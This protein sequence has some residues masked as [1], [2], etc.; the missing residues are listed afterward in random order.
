P[1]ET[2][3]LPIVPH[4]GGHEQRD[5]LL[6]HDRLLR[7]SRGAKSG[8]GALGGQ[9][10]ERGGRPAR[11]KQRLGENQLILAPRQ[12]RMLERARRI[13]T[14]GGIDLRDLRRRRRRRGDIEAAVV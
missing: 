10:G 7:R 14:G 5:V 2:G 11:L 3:A 12:N 8:A 13:E 4:L 1:R 6:L 9:E